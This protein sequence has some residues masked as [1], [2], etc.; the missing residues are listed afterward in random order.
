MISAKGKFS[1]LPY[2]LFTK[3]LKP[4]RIFSSISIEH[5]MFTFIYRTRRFP[6]NITGK[7]K[8]RAIRVKWSQSQDLILSWEVA[9]PHNPL[10]INILVTQ[11]TQE[12]PKII[13]ISRVEENITG[14]TPKGKRTVSHS[15]LI[16]QTR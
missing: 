14:S 1:F 13:L 10:L 8:G 4:I 12:I 11:C 7:E 2:V 15:F 5:E 16:P 9:Q 6:L 3:Y